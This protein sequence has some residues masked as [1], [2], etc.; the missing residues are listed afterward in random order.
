VAHESEAYE[1]LLAWTATK[2]DVPEA[3]ILDSQTVRGY[4]HHP[5]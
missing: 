1:R 4:R 5:R 3:D 2:Y